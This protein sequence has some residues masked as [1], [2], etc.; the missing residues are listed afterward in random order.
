VVKSALPLGAVAV[1]ATAFSY[2]DE[3]AANGIYGLPSPL[4][5]VSA[6]TRHASTSGE[7]RSKTSRSK[8]F[9]P[10]QDSNW[11]LRDPLSLINEEEY[12]NATDEEKKKMI[13]EATPTSIRTI[14]LVSQ[15]NRS[16]NWDESLTERVRE[17]ATAIGKTLAKLTR[18]KPVKEVVVSTTTK[19]ATETAEIIMKQLPSTVPRRSDS[20][21]D[22][23]ASDKDEYSLDSTFR[24]YMHRAPLEQKQN[25]TKVIVCH[26]EVIR[27][28]FCR[29]SIE[30]FIITKSSK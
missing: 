5:Q 22:K 16:Q 7:H 20:I 2:K 30:P 23:C 19:S 24:K 26:P 3:I 27:Y 9:V 1:T 6:S 15:R 4:R 8:Y 13:K 12:A 11:D 18:R 28:F 10:G 29:L 17:R 14:V 21:L 25:N